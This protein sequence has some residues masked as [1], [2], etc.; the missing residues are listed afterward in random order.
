MYPKTRLVAM[1]AMLLFGGLCSASA[2]A[3]IIVDFSSSNNFNANNSDLTAEVTFTEVNN[4]G[5]GGTLTILLQN[6]SSLA[7]LDDLSFNAASAGAF[8]IQ[9]VSTTQL[10]GGPNFADATIAG[11]GTP[12]TRNADGYGDFGYELNFKGGNN[13]RLDAGYSTTVVLTYTGSISDAELATATTA[14]NT[15]FGNNVAVLHFFLLGKTGYAGS[16]EG[17]TTQ[18]VPEPSTL[19]SAL[20][21]LALPGLA[22]LWRYR[23]RGAAVAA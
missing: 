2:E 8:T 16:G 13:S 22:L 10:S 4:V 9:S 23:R 20:I 3:S 7:Q 21:G 5:G 14:S 1:V 17:V 18:A 6:Q 19:G 15:D 11:T 12:Q